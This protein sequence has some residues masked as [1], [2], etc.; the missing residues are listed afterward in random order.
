MNITGHG[1]YLIKL[2]RFGVLNAFLV[3]EDDGFTLVDAI[4]AGSGA[5][6]IEAAAQQ[7]AEIKRIALTHAHVDHVGAVDEIKAALP[8]V[9]ILASAR[10]ARFLRDD[11]SVD[12]NEPQIKLRGAYTQIKSDV[13]RE[14][15]DGDQVASLRVVKSPGHTPGHIA[16]LDTRDN[17]LI[18]GDAFQTQGGIA[19]AGTIRLLFPL[20]AFGTWHRPLSIESAEGLHRLKPD[21][22]AVGHGPV[23]EHPQAAMAQAIEVARRQTG[24]T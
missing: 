11:P 6:I 19:V 7:G 13:D 9:T 2:T 18:A 17:S 3:R 16:F 5:A 4:I 22:L 14:L 20:P 1:D 10:D 23:L 12:P 8:D 21:R 24:L 15:A